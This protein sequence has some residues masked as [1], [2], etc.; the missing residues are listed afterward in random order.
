[1]FKLNAD[2][3]LRGYSFEYILRILL[4]R[5]NENNFIFQTKRFTKLKELKEK[6]KI[7]FSAEDKL[8]KEFIKKNWGRFDLI[9]FELNNKTERLIKNIIIYDVKTKD[10]PS[11]R[12]Y[13]DICE[14]S[15]NFFNE[16]KTQFNIPC[17]IIQVNIL[18][19]WKFNYIIQD[20]NQFKIRIYSRFKSG[21]IKNNTILPSL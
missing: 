15:Y 6:Y 11:K 3:N 10:Y 20:Y 2:Y 17:K 14:T 8:L 16:L 13:I 12:N 4:R 1:M 7:K 18:E 5:Q 9:E 21:N 19:N